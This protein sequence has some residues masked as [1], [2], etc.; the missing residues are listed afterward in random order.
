MKTIKLGA[1]QS[2]Q[3]EE[4][5]MG[6]RLY[7]D[8]VISAALALFFLQNGATCNPRSPLYYQAL[9]RQYNNTLSGNHDSAK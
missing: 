2:A 9:A 6:S 8:E 7:E 1:E 4:F 5:L 3:L